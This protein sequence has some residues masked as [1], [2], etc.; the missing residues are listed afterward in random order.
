MFARH[1]TR[2]FLSV[3]VTNYNA[4][5]RSPNSPHLS[6]ILFL[7][8]VLDWNKRKDPQWPGIL[9]VYRVRLHPWLVQTCPGIRHW[10]SEISRLCYRAATKGCFLEGPE[11]KTSA[12]HFSLLSVSHVLSALT[13]E[14]GLISWLWPGLYL[15]TG[16]CRAQSM[17]P[18]RLNKLMNASSN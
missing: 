1:C 6:V 2:C 4:T 9:L 18:I 17:A 14:S 5:L 7:P 12:T 15:H 8:C 16:D 3:I 13:L 11:I 10:P